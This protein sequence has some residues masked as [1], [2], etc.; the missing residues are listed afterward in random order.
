[1]KCFLIGNCSGKWSQPMRS[2]P[3]PFLTACSSLTVVCYGDV[4][5]SLTCGMISPHFIGFVIV[6]EL[7]TI[8]LIL[9]LN[10]YLTFNFPTLVDLN[11]SKSQINNLGSARSAKTWESRHGRQKQAKSNNLQVIIYFESNGS[12]SLIKLTWKE[13]LNILLFVLWAI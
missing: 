1:M 12:A 7:Q 9:N 5:C 6:Y 10:V 8:K 2:L 3:L 4:F 13:L 11:R